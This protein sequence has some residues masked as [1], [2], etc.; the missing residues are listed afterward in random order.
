MYGGHGYK[1][2]VTYVSEHMRNKGIS[3]KD[4]DKFMIENPARFFQF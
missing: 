4:L 1:N 3:Q 2:V